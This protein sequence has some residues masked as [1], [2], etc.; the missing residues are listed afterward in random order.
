D[1]VPDGRGKASGLPPRAAGT[2]Q[3]RAAASAVRRDRAGN[4]AR[5]T[6]GRA[7]LAARHESFRAVSPQGGELDED[8]LAELPA[9]RPDTRAAPAPW[10]AARAGAP[11]RERRAAARRLAA[12][13]F[14]RRG[15]AGRKPARG[16][17]RLAAARAEG[18][19]DLEAT[20]DRWSGPWP[21]EAGDLVTRSW[22]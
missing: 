9:A 13:V 19:L 7:E 15:A 20:L 5:R 2:G 8:P 17:R 14:F 18:D 11:A 4:A 22:Q 12:R 3:R 21:P 6:I 10:R 1:A 16:T